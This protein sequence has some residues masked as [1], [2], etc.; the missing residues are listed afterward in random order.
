VFPDDPSVVRLL[1]TQ[2][3]EIAEGRELERRF[4]SHESMQ[5]LTHPEQVLAA[6]PMPLRPAPVR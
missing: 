2:V 4:F 1:G 5:R 6:E 3:I